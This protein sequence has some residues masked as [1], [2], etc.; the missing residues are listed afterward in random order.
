MM[1]FSIVAVP[2]LTPEMLFAM[3]QFL[4]KPL[5]PKTTGNTPQRKKVLLSVIRQLL[6]IPSQSFITMAPQGPLPLILQ[7]LIVACV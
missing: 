5:H 2:T 1:Q 7:W 6:M 3:V 4:I